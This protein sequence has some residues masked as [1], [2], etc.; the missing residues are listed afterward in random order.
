MF[1]KLKGF[2]QIDWYP[3]VWYLAPNGK[4]IIKCCNLTFHVNT[5]PWKD[6]DV[7]QDIDN[8]SIIV[9]LESFDRR[10]SHNN[11]QSLKIPS[12]HLPKLKLIISNKY[13]S[14]DI[15]NHIFNIILISWNIFTERYQTMYNVGMT[16][17]LQL[18]LLLT[19]H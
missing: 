15:S 17:E 2:A 3:I 5:I 8:F 6:T 19:G 4:N 11:C 10:R 13:Y 7:S 1:K 12:C 18:L 9:S 16:V 14:I